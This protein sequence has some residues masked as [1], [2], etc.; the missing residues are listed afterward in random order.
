FPAGTSFGSITIQNS[1]YDLTGSSLTLT[2]G[3]SATYTTGTSAYEIPTS[4]TAVVAPIT[5]STG[6]TLDISDKGP[7]SGSAGVAVSGGGPL[8]LGAVNT[9]RG[10]TTIGPGTRLIVDG[11]VAGVQNTAGLL[12]GNGSVG[13]VTSVGGTILPGH[14]ATT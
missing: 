10:P 14:P 9:Y 1:G 5:V 6:G 11:T 13:G 3:I 12:A 8:A 4:L 7:L 2:A